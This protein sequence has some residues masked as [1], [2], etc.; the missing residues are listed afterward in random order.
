[1]EHASRRNQIEKIL[2]KIEEYSYSHNFQYLYP[3][4]LYITELANLIN[5]KSENLTFNN[6]INEVLQ[7]GI[8]EYI[9]ITKRTPQPSELS[10]ILHDISE[11][12][13]GAVY[14]SKFFYKAC[15]EFSVNALES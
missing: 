5:F 2:Q 14:W 10:L 7:P 11:I 4:N 9:L 8:Q 3:L 6:Y 13:R 15:E 12:K 1:M